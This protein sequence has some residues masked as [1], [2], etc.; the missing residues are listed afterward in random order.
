VSTQ[1]IVDVESASGRR[2]G[3][4]SRTW[5]EVLVAV[6]IVV[7]SSRALHSNYA[8]FGL[9][10]DGR[11]TSL[12]RLI[13][14][15]LALASVVAVLRRPWLV[16]RSLEPL[17]VA[18]IGLLC[19]SV[20]WSVDAPKTLYQV[21][22]LVSVL[23]C[24]W[25]LSIVFGRDEG[26]ALVSNVLGVVCA[27]NVAAVLLGINNGI[28]TTT[29]YFEHKNIFGLVAAVSVLVA[30]ARRVGGHDRSRI[31]V[32]IAGVSA[33]ALFLSGS[34][35]SQFGAVFVLL[36]FGFI[37]LR[38]RNQTMAIAL[39]APAIAAYAVVLRAA[40]GVAAVLTASGKSSDLTGRT[41]VWGQVWTLVVER[42]ITG[43]GYLAYW[44]DTGFGASGRSGF[45]EFGLRSAH[46]GYLEAALGAGVLAGAVVAL[47]LIVLTVRSYRRLVG[48]ISGAVAAALFGVALFTALVNLS[49]TLFP[50]TTRTLLTLLIAMFSAGP[51][52]RDR[53]T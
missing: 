12:G 10:A 5:I 2:L 34:R 43:W 52:M 36:M 3:G 15:T 30:V 48:G 37:S 47:V 6:L 46:N 9:I 38:R 41:D 53:S 51:M 8:M 27:V 19:I 23:A 24:A 31:V 29:G 17:V 11:L 40:G 16:R 22:V 25:F 14:P 39:V 50:A 1:E 13:W 45:E 20:V 26:V 32:L 35:T 49:E 33:V 42:P 44:R 4:V 21:I 28:G 7:H 18:A